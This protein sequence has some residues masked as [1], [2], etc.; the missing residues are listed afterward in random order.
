MLDGIK[1]IVSTPLRYMLRDSCFN[2]TECLRGFMKLSI[3]YGDSERLNE[4]H[5]FHIG[6]YILYKP[7]DL[8]NSYVLYIYIKISNINWSCHHVS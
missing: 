8:Y 6:V 3:W 4:D 1:P 5:N 7:M 2:N